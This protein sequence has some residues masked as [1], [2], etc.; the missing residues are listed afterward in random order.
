MASFST[1]TT[2]TETNPNTTEPT[3]Q[4]PPINTQQFPPINTQQLPPVTPISNFAQS[5]T[6]LNK[7]NFM[8]WRRL[9]ESFLCGHN[10]YGFIDGT[11]T[12]SLQVS[13]SPSD[14]LTIST[15][16]DTVQWL[17]QDQLVL[18]MLMSSISDEMLPQIIS[19]KTAQ[20]LWKTL[21]QTFTSES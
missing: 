20:E 9:V 18:S 4:L 16:P 17:R 1:E 6:K 19:C 3:Q 2:S 14:T 21:D 5:I 15:N 11:N 13:T 12:P 8:T 7:G 10:L